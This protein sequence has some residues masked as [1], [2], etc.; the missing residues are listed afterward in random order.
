MR[1][2][3]QLHYVCNFL[4]MFLYRFDLNVYK[5]VI[6]S[7]IYIIPLCIY[8]MLLLLLFVSV[9]FVQTNSSFL[10]VPPPPFKRSDVLVE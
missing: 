6:H 4:C 2:I 5:N 1:T 10:Q 9:V 7:S 3:Y 8:S